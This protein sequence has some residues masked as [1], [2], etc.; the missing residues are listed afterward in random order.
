MPTLLEPTE[1]T[2]KVTYDDGELVITGRSFMDNA[3][4]FYTNLIDNIKGLPAQHLNVVVQLDYFNTSSSKCMLEL[5]RSLE[6]R[7]HDG[8]HTASIKW[9]YAAECYD[10]EEAGEDYR[11]LISGVPFE[12]VEDEE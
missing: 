11:D 10:I 9:H 12:L 5:F 1:R 8:E 7:V 3:I 4:D 6:R 2:P